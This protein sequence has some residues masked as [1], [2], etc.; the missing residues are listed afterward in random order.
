M[1]NHKSNIKNN[2]EYF[3]MVA[4]I[5]CCSYSDYGW[6]NVLRNVFNYSMVSLLIS[7][8]NNKFRERYE[9]N[10]FVYSEHT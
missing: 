1:N 9:I 4:N 6:C 10:N 3:Y 8:M 5:N 7:F 2:S